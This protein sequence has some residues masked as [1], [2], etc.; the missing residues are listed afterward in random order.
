[1]VARFRTTL[2]NRLIVRTYATRGAL[3]WVATR[4]ILIAIFLRGGFDP[5][6]LS[7]AAMG[8]VVLLSVVVCF[9]ETYRRHERALLGNLAVRPVTLIVLFA[10]PALLGEVAIRIVR[11]VIA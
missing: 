5:F 6:Q 3:L 9:L 4:A 10:T 8:G 1:M 11:L 7:A 2:P